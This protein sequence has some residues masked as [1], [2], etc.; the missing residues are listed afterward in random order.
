MLDAMRLNFLR[1]GAALFLLAVFSARAED[2]NAATLL[3]KIN[4]PGLQTD[5][6]PALAPDGTVYQGTF[7]GWMLA[8]SSAGKIKWQ[9][10]AGREIK[11]S[12]AV[13]A[14]GTIYFGSRDR[15][16]YAVAADG[17][18]KWKFPTGAWVDSSPALAEDGTIYFGSHD[19]IFYALTPD[20]KLKWKFLT[21][22]IISASP[23]VAADGTVYFGG[24]DKNFYALTTDGKL[25]WKFATGGEIDASP[26]LAADSTIY[27][28]STDGLLHAL[29]A[30]GTE[31]WNVRTGGY[32]GSTAVLD[33]KGNIYVCA[34]KDHLFISPQGKITFRHDTDVPM[35]MSG[36]VT[37][38]RQVIFSLPWLRLGSFDL[39]KQWPP[40][41]MFP[42]SFNLAGSPNVDA[43]GN[44]YVSNG[45][46]L[47]AVKPPN[48][49]PPAKSSW[50]LWRGNAQQTGRAAK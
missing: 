17:K 26:T 9:F 20:G 27:F 30:D 14:D 32:T 45:W 35:D 15:N 41:W 39:D 25:K 16:F 46:N 33:E 13:G 22:G 28:T 5:S 24:H 6:S 43:Q 49:A 40:A 37:A 12:P 11:S 50:P 21:G 2:T 19:K 31:R 29:A 1:T 48:A 8:V 4:L 44:I 18:L 23:S 47:L 3:W 7:H 42:M 34:A 38:N 10:K 36:A